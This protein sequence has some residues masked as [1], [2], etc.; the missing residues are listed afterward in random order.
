MLRLKVC[1]QV[2]KLPQYIL[3][4]SAKTAYSSL[5][6]L[7][8]WL[9]R[10]G[11]TQREALPHSS[12]RWWTEGYLYFSLSSPTSCFFPNGSDRRKTQ[13]CSLLSPPLV[14]LSSQASPLISPSILE[15]K[16]CQKW[17]ESSSTDSQILKNIWF[18]FWPVVVFVT[19]RAWLL[20]G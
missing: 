19:L 14:T 20:A 9:V 17:L 8:S 16:R 10:Q 2:L 3:S 7:L 12:D 13:K 18:T 6:I 11:R 4:S 5:F 15:R 1:F